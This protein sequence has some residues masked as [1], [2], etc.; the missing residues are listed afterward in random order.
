[1]AAHADA[2]DR[3]K[4][5]GKAEAARDKVKAGKTEQHKSTILRYITNP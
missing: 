1:V 2:K 3:A 5:G 4:S